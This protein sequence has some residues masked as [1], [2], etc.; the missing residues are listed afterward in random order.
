MKEISLTQDQVAFIDD[1]DFERVN[2][3]KWNAGW[4]EGIQSY[5]AFRTTS[6]R[7]CM[8]MSRFIVD[9]EDPDKV[10]DHKNHD[11]L[12]NQKHNLRICTQSENMQ[13]ARKRA[14]ATSRY[15]G[16]CWEKVNNKWRARIGLRDIFD[17]KF[18]KYLGH[19]EIE[20]EAALAYDEAAIKYFG[21][22]AYLNFP[23]QK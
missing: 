22:F 20:E 4:S 17:R 16:V 12:D 5:Y 23:R 15:K 13:N 2:Q 7:Q 8:L 21:E 9:C 19:F 14:N 11:T 6:S 10:V 1:E 18:D 3:F